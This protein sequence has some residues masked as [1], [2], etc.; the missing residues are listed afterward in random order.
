MATLQTI[1]TKAG[2][3]IA[4]VIGISLAA[5][6]LGDL[7]QS[8]SSIMNKNKMKIGE[9]NGESIQYP[10]FQKQVEELGEIYK[11]NTQQSQLDENSWVQVREQTW[12]TTVQNI[13]MSDVYKDLGIEVSSEEL[14][15]MLTG[16]NLHPI[17]QQMFRNP[18]TGQVDRGAVVN[19]LKQLDTNV[20]PE[21]RAY[22][23]YLENQIVTERTQ[24]KYTNM[25]GKG[26][27]VTTNE[28]QQSLEDASKQ[29]N[30]DYISLNLNTVADSALKVNESDL[31]AYYNSHKKDFKQEKIRDLEYITFNV[32][33]SA[34]DYK[35]AEK[36]IT[37]IKDDFA[38]ATDNAQFV[39]SNSDIIFDGT[40]Y[41]KA[42][43]PEN[44][45]TWIF[46]EN[47]GPNDVLGPYFE[48]DS[49][50]LAKLDSMAM[51]PDS[52]QARHILL[53]PNTQEE[54]GSM[55]LLADSLKAAIEKG[56]NFA[57]LA[58]QFSTDQGSAMNGGDLGWFGRG[59]MVK[60]FEEAAFE[61][62]KN[63][64]SIVPSQFGIHIIQTTDRGKLTQ[65][66]RVATLVR[67]VQPSTRT[68]QDMY[69]L[70]SKFA[71]TNTDAKKF[72]EAIV[73][74]K[75]NKRVASVRE[76]DR[77]IAGLENAR[78]L[79]RAAYEA[80]KGDI[81]ATTQ[82]SPIFELGNNFVI[83]VLTKATE[84][85]E[86]TFEEAKTKVE[87]AVTKEKKTEYLVKKASNA[88]DGKTDLQ[89]VASQLNTNVQNA[90]N[91]NFNSFSIP[92]IGME[93]AVVGTITALEI[94]KI[95]KPIAGNSGV[96]VVKVTSVNQGPEQGVDAEQARLAQ[97]MENRATSQAYEA[98]R[99]KA[100][101]EDYRAKFY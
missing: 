36:W 89:A 94:D 12:Q 26:L 87:L 3:L 97:S 6:I 8:G 2:L 93:P 75:L 83:A 80:D 90:A 50:S 20:A 40:W 28:A 21:N 44:V 49:Y 59:Q 27:F 47:P 25:V 70:A 84:E 69:A 66:V 16:A 61:N 96:Y 18:N 1:R 81:L 41:K 82:G 24:S 74:E 54:L 37:E 9:I 68:Y 67:K 85:G 52:V 7:L 72:N 78:T 4:I 63:E 38:N 51:M 53:K 11:Q 32:K 76:N 13:V 22:W 55:Q 48:N 95:S 86:S 101:I 29:V 19:F 45:A 100:D 98:Q 10:E 17:I 60:P 79:I 57:A 73:A 65:Q 14:Y 77:D 15:D 58:M 92:G 99:K 42:S 35:D 64:V 34:A 71:S 43:L 88:L 62:A 5:F 33:P 91:I 46:D 31:K 30:F 39:N 23:L 56:S